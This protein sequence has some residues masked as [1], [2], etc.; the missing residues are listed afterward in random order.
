MWYRIF[1]AVIVRVT[2][3]VANHLANSRAFQRLVRELNDTLVLHLERMR[4]PARYR[5][6]MNERELERIAELEKEL[7]QKSTKP[8]SAPSNT[9]E[10]VSTYSQPHQPPGSSANPTRN[11]AARQLQEELARVHRAPNQYSKFGRWYSSKKYNL[12]VWWRSRFG[13]K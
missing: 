12:Q 2:P 1:M 9:S 13:P 5:Q 11:T 8:P 6:M 10:K 3:I 7:A 4:N